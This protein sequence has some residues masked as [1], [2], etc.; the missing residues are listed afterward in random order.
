MTFFKFII[1]FSTFIIFD[2]N[3]VLNKPKYGKKTQALKDKTPVQSKF[4]M[5]NSKEELFTLG[6][7]S[8][9]QKFKV[10][11][12]I[13]IIVW[14]I[15]NGVKPKWKET[16]ET[17]IKDRDLILLQE[18]NLKD[19]MKKVFNSDPN[20]GYTCATAFIEA[21]GHVLTGVATASKVK[22]INTYVLRGLSREP[23][24]DSSKVT[25]FSEFK[26]EGLK[27]K[28]LVVNVHA[29]TFVRSKYLFDQL[30]GI[31]NVFMF[32][33][34]PLIVAGDFNTWKLTHIKYLDK[35]IKKNNLI[36]VT[37]EKDLRIHTFNEKLDH[38]FVR[39]FD[40]E[41]SETLLSFAG[42][43]HNAMTAILKF[44]KE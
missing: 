30:D 40:I 25:L 26:V 11:D 3:A 19:E 4:L 7:F 14:N 32:H 24:V 5:P 41:K 16:Y 21:E 31:A 37:F 34:G 28:L 29:I 38:I 20:L 35:I 22:P 18:F 13:N 27:E 36:E 15:Y 10:T 17:F 1:L 6:K 43:D 44:K 39:G 23:I 8:D 9:S 33:K 2:T 12:P 42:S